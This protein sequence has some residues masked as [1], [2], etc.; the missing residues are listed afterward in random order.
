MRFVEVDRDDSASL[1][2]SYPMQRGGLSTSEFRCSLREEPRHLRRA[3]PRTSQRIC[4][5][6]CSSRVVYDD[7]LG[8]KSG[9]GKP[10]GRERG[11]VGEEREST[12]EGEKGKANEYEVLEWKRGGSVRVR[13]GKERVREGKGRE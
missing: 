6:C 5:S 11:V 8:G 9:R 3:T 7:G 4:D 10:L 13:E 12:Y 1:E 2:L